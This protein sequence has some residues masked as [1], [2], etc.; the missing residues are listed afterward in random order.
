MFFLFS[1]ALS[2][3]KVVFFFFPNLRACPE[4]FGSN[5]FLITKKNWLLGMVNLLSFEKIIGTFLE[6]L[7]RSLGTALL[8]MLA[9]ILIA[10][11]KRSSRK[12]LDI[13]PWISLLTCEK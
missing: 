1:G 8:M 11:S 4:V 5:I 2:R 3:G 12:A 9:L 10:K 7:L 13:G 6:S